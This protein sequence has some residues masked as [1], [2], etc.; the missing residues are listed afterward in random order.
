MTVTGVE[1]VRVGGSPGYRAAGM[2]SVRVFPYTPGDAES[3]EA[4]RV[5][6]LRSAWAIDANRRMQRAGRRP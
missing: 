4:A 6:A 3:R 2:D 5:A 1:R